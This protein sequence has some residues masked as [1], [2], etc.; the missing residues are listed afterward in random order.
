[1]ITAR[2]QQ[3][4]AL[5]RAARARI[6]PRD[7]GLRDSQFRRSPG[8]RREDVAVLAGLSVKWY[9]WLEQGRDVNFSADAL[10]RVSTALRLSAA[11]HAYLLALTQWRG[12]PCGGRTELSEALRRTVKFVPVPMLV[13]TLRWDVV[14]WNPLVSRIF[15]DYGMYPA[16]QRNLLRIVLTEPRFQRDAAIYDDVARKLLGEFRLDFAQRAGDPAFEA[17]IAELERAAPGFETRW[18]RVELFSGRRTSVIAH[19]ELGQLSFDRLSYVPEDCPSFRVL[20][21]VP[22]DV[23]TAHVVASLASDPLGDAP[24]PRA[25]PRHPAHEPLMMPALD[26]EIASFRAVSVGVHPDCASRRDDG[27]GPRHRPQARPTSAP[28]TNT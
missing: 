7:V 15:R 11:E 27:D 2:K 12:T 23:R 19:D 16:D 5:L 24:L 26:D 6:D 13:M 18:S 10:K 8:L 25:R 9:T 14:A 21:Y 3:V 17:L 4:R 20:M 22:G 1:M 28:R